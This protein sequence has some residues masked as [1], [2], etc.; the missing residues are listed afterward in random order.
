MWFYS[1]PFLLSMMSMHFPYGNTNTA[2]QQARSYGTA[3]CPGFG[4][5]YNPYFSPPFY[6]NSNGLQPT[7]LMPPNRQCK[8]LISKPL[9]P[10]SYP[11]PFPMSYGPM[12]MNN[13]KD[14]L[15]F[16]EQKPQP[17]SGLNPFAN[18]FSLGKNLPNGFLPGKQEKSSSY[19]L[20]FDDLIEKSLKS[21]HAIE[22]ASK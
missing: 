6:S 13:S 15:T 5:N 7:P 12:P 18:E 3:V 21:I 22:K 20:I 9:V 10:N 16:L 11:P 8:E 17:I 19:Q 1:F 4:I 2:G 14:F